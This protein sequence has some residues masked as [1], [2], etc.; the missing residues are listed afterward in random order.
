[1]DSLSD[2][3]DINRAWENS[4][5]DIKTSAKEIRSTYEL[6]QYKSRFDEECLGF[7]IKRSRLKCSGNRIQT[8]DEECLG[9]CIK[10]SRLKCSGNKIQTIDEECL[11]FCIKR[12]RLKCS[13]NR[14]Q[15]IDEECLGFCIKRS[16]LK[17]SGNGIQTKT[18]QIKKA[19]S[20]LR[21]LTFRH[22]ASPI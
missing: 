13:G 10:R 9:F 3:E 18:T 12:S 5:K 17:C 6:K 16:R 7:C 15:T 8:T 21:P 14:I 22:H 2:K 1:L 11:G 19:Y 20:R 4:K